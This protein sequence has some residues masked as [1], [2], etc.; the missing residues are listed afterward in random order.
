M[1]TQPKGFELY[2]FII[3]DST[4]YEPKEVYKGQKV[5]DNVQVLRQMSSDRLHQEMINQQYK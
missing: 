1:A 4:F 3:K 2:S 5:I